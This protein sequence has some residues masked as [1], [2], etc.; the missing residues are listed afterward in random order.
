MPSEADVAK[1][2]FE[3]IEPVINPLGYELVEVEYCHR[4]GAMQLTVFVY[5]AAGISLDDCERVHYVIDPL[6]DGLD[7]TNGAPYNL[8]VSSP[9][10][11]RPIVTDKDYSRNVDREL[12]IRLFA[13]IDRKRVFVATLISFNGTEA[14]FSESETGKEMVFERAKISK[15]TQNIKF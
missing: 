9:G 10:L 15:L 6:L 5:S 12:E 11:D 8:N 1:K 4:H 14:V 3:C 13:P 2:V 7:P